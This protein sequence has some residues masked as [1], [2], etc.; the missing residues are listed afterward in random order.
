[1]IQRRRP[2]LKLAWA[3]AL[4]GVALMFAPVAGATPDDDLLR[5]LRVDGIAGPSDDTLLKSAHSA[6]DLLTTMN[7]DQVDS[8]VHEQ[9]SLDDN[10]SAVF[11]A[12]AMHSLCPEQDHSG[13]QIWQTTHPGG[14]ALH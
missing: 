8:A 1:M 9:T 11:V 5:Q 10:Q 2:Q 7:G 6:C 14:Q 4:T 13:G 12:D 3:G